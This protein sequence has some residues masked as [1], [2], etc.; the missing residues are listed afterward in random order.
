MW[1]KMEKWVGCGARRLMQS[2][3]RK[4]PRVSLGMGGNGV[5]TES[6]AGNGR[7]AENERNGK[8]TWDYRE[9]RRDRGRWDRSK[10]SS[11]TC[12]SGKA[13]SMMLGWPRGSPF[14][15]REKMTWYPRIWPCCFPCSGGF[16]VTRMAVEF[17]ASTS[18]FLGGAPGTGNQKTGVGRECRQECK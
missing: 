17:M 6:K 9:R 2:T 4:I 14:S 15:S 11:S 12:A 5:W 3:E 10:T 1:R 7:A 13:T 8:W 16:Q 18:S